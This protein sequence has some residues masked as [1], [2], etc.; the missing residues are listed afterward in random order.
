MRRHAESTRPDIA[1]SASAP[2]GFTLVELVIAML[3]LG[4]V[5]GGIY[6]LLATAQRT[7]R[8]QFEVAGMQAT[9]RAGA[10][11]LSAE[12]REL[13]YDSVPGS[14]SAAPDILAMAAE[15]VA[16][17]AV[18]ASGLVCGLADNE[19]TIDTARDYSAS[20][21]PVASTDSV[22]LFAEVNP[23]NRADDHWVRRP[24]TGVAPGPCAAAPPWRAR[25]GL[26]LTTP[27]RW[28][29]GG[30]WPSDSFTLG[31]PVRVFE[32]VI[33]RFYSSG[34]RTW[35]GS[36]AGSGGS[37]QPVLGPLAR[38][39]GLAYFDAAGNATATPSQVRSVQITLVGETD[40][41]VPVGG[42][43]SPRFQSDTL[44]TLVSLRNTLR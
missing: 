1:R 22:M 17:R 5:G 28:Q 6:K 39:S 2:A 7:S 8:A 30:A 12:L 31:S 20:R 34:G 32:P 42:S 18:R 14:P 27:V 10:L 36:Y 43:G 26:R 16:I 29:S 15:S 33:Y 13:G 25:A 21:L 35:L 44:I 37:I 11:I 41:P 38:S 9:L 19:V 23:A 40:Q 4:S 24:V 3:L